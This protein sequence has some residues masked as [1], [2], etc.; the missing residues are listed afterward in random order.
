[1]LIGW[2]GLAALANL[3]LPITL[4]VDT[5]DVVIL[6]LLTASDKER[7]AD[8]PGIDTCQMKRSNL[9]KQTYNYWIFFFFCFRPLFFIVVQ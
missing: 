1:M 3:T 4:E 5:V 7:G 9:L 2:P 6:E 8:N